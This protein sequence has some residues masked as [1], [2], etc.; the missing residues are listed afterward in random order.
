MSQIKSLSSSELV[1]FGSS[2]FT[3]HSPSR[4]TVLEFEQEGTYRMVLNTDDKVFG[5]FERVDA[6][7][8]FFTTPGLRGMVGRTSPRSIFLLGLLFVSHQCREIEEDMLMIFRYLLLSR[9]CEVERHTRSVHGW[10]RKLLW[11]F[12]RVYMD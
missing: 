10:D 4:I 5:G 8:R 1:C 11:C 6:G 3:L 12:R 2:I 7:T 9:H